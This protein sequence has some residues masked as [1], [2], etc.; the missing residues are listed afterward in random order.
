MKVMDDTVVSAESSS[1]WCP[2]QSGQVTGS[3]LPSFEPQLCG[4]AGEGSGL[5]RYVWGAGTFAPP[6]DRHPELSAAIPGAP[7]PQEG[8]EVLTAGLPSAGTG[9]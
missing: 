1:L 8:V 2:W 9:D 7:A 5:S 6:F 3:R 4:E